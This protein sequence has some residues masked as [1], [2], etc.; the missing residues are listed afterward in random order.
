MLEV[1][2]GEIGSDPPFLVNTLFF[3]TVAKKKRTQ[4]NWVRYCLVL[5]KKKKKKRPLGF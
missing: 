1:G 2:G 5:K 3:E 4:V